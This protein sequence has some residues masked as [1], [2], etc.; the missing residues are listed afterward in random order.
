MKTP[1]SRIFFPKGSSIMALR[2]LELKINPG[3]GALTVEIYINNVYFNH[4]T[5]VDFDQNFFPL[6]KNINEIQIKLLNE[7]NF[8][9][10][11]QILLY[12]IINN[13]DDLNDI[14]NLDS[15][16]GKELER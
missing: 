1:I 3:L 16:L 6:I 11:K 7:T 13:K 15:Y 8:T 12:P 14:N 9:Y 10:S 4:K 2:C 5:V